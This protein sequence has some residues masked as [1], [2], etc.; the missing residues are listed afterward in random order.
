MPK[1][2]KYIDS[3][4]VFISGEHGDGLVSIKRLIFI[5][6]LNY[7]KEFKR[8]YHNNCS[9]STKRKLKKGC[10]STIYTKNS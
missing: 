9:L 1:I 2:W 10:S 8:K 3:D 4:L 5:I 7:T 6:S